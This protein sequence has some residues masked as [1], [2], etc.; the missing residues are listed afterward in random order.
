MEVLVAGNTFGEVSLRNQEYVANY[1]FESATRRWIMR[2]CWGH[3]SPC[4][5]RA[6]GHGELAV[7][8]LRMVEMVVNQVSYLRVAVRPHLKVK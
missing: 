3:R 1:V 8:A 5:V 4:T 7:G 2:F 6:K